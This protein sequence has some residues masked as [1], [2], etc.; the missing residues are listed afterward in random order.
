MNSHRQ[1]QAIQAGDVAV[2]RDPNTKPSAPETRPLRCGS[3]PGGTFGAFVAW[4]VTEVV[5]PRADLIGGRCLPA[6]RI[7]RGLR[8]WP[9]R[10]SLAPAAGSRRTSSPPGLREPPWATKC[11]GQRTVDPRRPAIR[12][13]VARPARTRSPSCRWPSASAWGWPR[14]GRS[15]RSRC[16]QRRSTMPYGPLGW[17]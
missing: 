14:R 4:E 3:D 5:Q 7:E 9:R 11:R 1:V 10:E 6:G 17:R 8:A 2:R 13:R 15:P 12:S 16:C